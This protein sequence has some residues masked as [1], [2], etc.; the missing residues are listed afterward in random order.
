MPRT[1]A[2]RP[3]LRL[4]D[5]VTAAVSPPAQMHWEG[6]IVIEGVAENPT[7]DGRAA[8]HG[9][10]SWTVPFPLT[11]E[12]DGGTHDRTVVV[13]TV[14]EVERQDGGRIFARGTFDLNAPST[15]EFPDG[16]GRE[17]ARQVAEGLT[18]DV[19]IEPDSITSELRV[20]QEVIDQ[21]QDELDAAE[22]GDVPLAD[23]GDGDADGDG[24]VTLDTFRHDD[25]LEVVIEGRIRTLA[26][27]TTAAFD[28]AQIGLVEGWAA[29]EAAEP[30]DDGVDMAAEFSLAAAATPGVLPPQS[31][32]DA[33]DLDR[34]TPLT[35]SNTGRIFGHIAG[36][37]TCHIGIQ[38]RCVT[39]PPSPSGYAHFMVH[40]TEAVCDTGCDGA[41]V[42]VPVGVLTMSTGH[43][44]EH[45]DPR[46]AARHYDDTGTQAAYVTAGEDAHGIW[47][48]GWVL[49]EV[50]QDPAL[51]RRLRASAPSG[52]WR[53]I[54]GHLELVA[55][56]QVNTPGFPVARLAASAA[57]ELR[58]RW[59]VDG[60]GVQTSLIASAP[61]LAV[62]EDGGQPAGDP[63]VARMLSVLLAERAADADRAYRATV[64]AAKARAADR[65][66]A[67]V[68]R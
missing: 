52:D 53:R 35:V 62:V 41:T 47:V 50:Q 18:V 25:W 45:A 21:W 37:G 36:W 28:D 59:A 46:A 2:R 67:R 61:D 54:G 32:F 5:A 60:D 11:W 68:R 22:E 10:W 38:G 34:L 3:P 26:M 9:A 57:P 51:M 8:E 65:L 27:V 49:P 63:E 40:E 15:P 1:A 48:A 17:A 56:L 23:E 20:R 64:G 19:S 66:A 12:R 39:P 4:R 14:W 7:G 44:D 29:D 33:P 31:W 30:A 13:G 24:R 6:V 42:T 16:I 58:T 55:S 43:A